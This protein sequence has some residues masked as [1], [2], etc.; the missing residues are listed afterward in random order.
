MQFVPFIDIGSAWS[1]ILNKR[2]P[3]WAI[4]YGFGLRTSLLSY[5]VRV[6]L[7]WQNISQSNQ[8]RPMLVIGMEREY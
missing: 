8:R 7:A 3:A 4:G 5:F 6:D 1:V 2:I